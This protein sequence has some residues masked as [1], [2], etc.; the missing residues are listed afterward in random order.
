MIDGR[1]WFERYQPISYR[2]ETRSGSAEEFRSMVKR[3]AAAGVNIYVDVLLNHMSANQGNATGTGH[4]MADTNALDY[5]GVPYKE[6]HFHHPIC[7]I[8]NYNNATNVRN[9]E[10]VGLHDLNQS[11]EYVREKIVGLLNDA[12][13]AGVAGFRF[14]FSLMTT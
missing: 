2:W 13:D 3:C 7:S 5:P 14:V 1:P 9:C 4:S 11:Q 10:L 8:E 6:I 12:V